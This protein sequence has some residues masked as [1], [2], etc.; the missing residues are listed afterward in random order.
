MNKTPFKWEQ[1][2]KPFERSFFMKGIKYTKKYIFMRG[3][4]Y[5][6]AILLTSKEKK[7]KQIGI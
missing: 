6:A 2:R 7:P 1:F 5:V 4:I 3:A